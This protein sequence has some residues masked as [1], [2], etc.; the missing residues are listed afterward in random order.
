[1]IFRCLIVDDESGKVQRVR[2]VIENEVGISE[3]S[4]LRARSASEATE[5]LRSHDFD[6]VVVDLNLPLR[7]NE[8][9]VQD[10]GIRLLKQIA[11]GTNS[12]RRPMAIVGLTA[13]EDLATTSTPVFQEHGWALV[14]YSVESSEWERSLVNQCQHV[15]SCKRR[16]LA[17]GAASRYDVC[18]VTA[19]SETELEAVLRLPYCWTTKV[20]EG[21]DTRYETGAIETTNGKLSVLACSCP[22]MGNSAAAMMAAKIVLQF[23]PKMIILSGIC[24]GIAAKIG[25]IAIAEFALHHDAGKW[26][27]GDGGETVFQPQPRYREAGT[28]VLESIKR[29]ILQNKATILGIPSSWYGSV[30]EKAPEVHVGP[31]ASG[32]AVVEN[33]QIV[34]D[35]KF[36][37]RKL[38]GLEMESYGFYLGVSKAAAGNCQSIMIKGVCDTASPPKTDEFQ[39]YAAFL[40]A[41]FVDG[42]LR[43]EMDVPGGIFNS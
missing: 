16:I 38:V 25:D 4:I 35:L 7:T 33:K 27:E 40:S 3:A 12:L 30:P 1:M 28:R 13:F 41:Q 17:E 37:D 32:A 2:E 42:F 22:E 39:K 18:I 19:L 11:R 36:R 24:A 31:V 29:F 5:F 26:T 23:R 15:C 10:G 6:L 21:D 8:A 34:C 9:P 20:F 43:V 14:T